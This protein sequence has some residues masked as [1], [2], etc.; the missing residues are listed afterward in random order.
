MVNHRHCRQTWAGFTLIELLVVLAIVAMLA[1][2]V[3]PR[4]FHGI[5]RAREASLHTSLATMRDAIDKFDG[6]LG[7]YPTS[8]DEL[9]E[10]RYIREVPIDPVTGRRDTWVI[11]PPPTDAVV[12]DG[13]ADVRS[14]APGAGVDGV[15]FQ[16]Y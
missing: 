1:A 7:R 10:R 11:V 13:V 16:S 5:D 14:G 2:I 8:L 15:P 3:S 4:Y 9:V 12:A 6:D